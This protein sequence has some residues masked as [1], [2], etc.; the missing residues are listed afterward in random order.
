MN[1]VDPVGEQRASIPLA[2]NGKWFICQHGGGDLSVKNRSWGHFTG[3][4]PHTEFSF[5]LSLRPDEAGRQGGQ[6]PGTARA[7]PGRA[8][9]VTSM[10]TGSCLQGIIQVPLFKCVLHNC[11]PEQRVALD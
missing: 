9:P 11:L 5:S 10:T 2:L 3:S 6:Q 1:V 7:H 4:S 8:E